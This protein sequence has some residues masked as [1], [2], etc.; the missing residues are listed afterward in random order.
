MSTQILSHS[1]LIK[2]LVTLAGWSFVMEVWMYATR[3]PAISKYKINTD[4]DKVANEFK[5]KVPI[6]IQQIADNYNHLHEQPTVFYAVVLALALIGDNHPNTL[7]A[8]WTYVGL[9]ITH[10]VFQSLVNKVMVRFQI[11]LTSSIVV[12]GLTARL[13]TLVY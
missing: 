5:T 4:P 10:S 8:A 1:A 9:R 12:G 2:P 13:A 6:S 3:I 7:K 11:F